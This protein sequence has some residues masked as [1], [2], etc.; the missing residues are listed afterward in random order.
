M[1]L[2]AALVAPGVVLNKDGVVEFEHANELQEAIDN[3]TLAGGESSYKSV[4]GET[5]AQQLQDSL[6]TSQTLSA[7][8]EAVSLT[9]DF[10]T[11]TLGKQF[12]Q[13]ARVIAA[14]SYVKPSLP[15]SYPRACPL[16]H[17][18]AGR[19]PCSTAT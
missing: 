11:A 17:W 4:F 5:W 1:V 13:V 8:L 19:P 3:I 14:R 18:H 7:A 16:K 9:A 12:E 6:G 15:P 2:P 10:G